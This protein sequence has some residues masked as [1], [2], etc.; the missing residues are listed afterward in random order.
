MARLRVPW[1]I[2]SSSRVI[3]HLSLSK[4]AMQPALHSMPIDRSATLPRSGNSDAMV[5]EGGKFGRS[6]F[7]VCVDR[8]VVP[9]GRLMVTGMVAGW[10]CLSMGRCM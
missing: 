10:M 2:G 5:A 4:V 1:R 7:P 8:I 6:R 9:S 3:V